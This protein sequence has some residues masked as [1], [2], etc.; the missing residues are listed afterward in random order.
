MSMR[1]PCFAVA[2]AVLSL[3]SCAAAPA[4]APTPTPPANNAA[5]EQAVLQLERDWCEA[6]RSGNA[7]TVARIEDDSY[8]FTNSRAE[9]STKADDVG[10]IRA[11]S[12]EYSKFESREQQVRLYGDT[13]V[14]TGITA[15]EGVSGDKPFKL[16]VRFTDT[17]L[18]HG[19]EWKAVAAQVTKIED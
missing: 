12:V 11:R 3:C 15:L 18:R 1:L 10:E 6:F 17:L 7:D 13:A 19:T 2:V 8:V 4:P 16:D 14:V 9:L 5:D